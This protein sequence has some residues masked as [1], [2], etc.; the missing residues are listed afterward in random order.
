MGSRDTIKD[1]RM[2]TLGGEALRNQWIRNA[3]RLNHQGHFARYPP[4]QREEV[5]RKGFLGPWPPNR[6]IVIA[7]E[8]AEKGQAVRTPKFNDEMRNHFGLV[9]E[10]VREAVVKILGELPPES[11][12][13]PAE[14]QEPCGCP[15]RFRS[16]TLGG[17]VYFKFQVRGTRK[18]RVLF[19]SCHPPVY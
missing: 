6:A 10:E 2:G 15:F 9:G 12:E 18:P 14:L 13:P 19:W 11:Y 5:L 1:A 16:K 3:E 8:Q 7:R 17:E 4:R